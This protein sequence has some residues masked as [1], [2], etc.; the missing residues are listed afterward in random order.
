MGTL[1][2]ELASREILPGKTVLDLREYISE[3]HSSLSLASKASIFADAINRII[4]DKIPQLP[5]EQVKQFK[6]FLFRDVANKPTFS[7]NGSDIFISSL[8]LKKADDLYVE[9]LSQWLEETLRKPVSK[10]R[11]FQF[12]QYTHKTMDEFSGVDFGE[13]IESIEEKVGDI[14]AENFNNS[15]ASAMINPGS[16]EPDKEVEAFAD[17]AI[18]TTPIRY[19]S[20]DLSGMF[21]ANISIYKAKRK[22][23][24]LKKGNQAGALAAAGLVCITVLLLYFSATFVNAEKRASMIQPEEIVTLSL[25][26]L[27]ASKLE[28][29]ADTVQYENPA[30][31]MKATAYDLSFES[32][33]KERSHPEYGI[34]CTGTKASVG[35]T[36]AVDPAVIPLGSSVKITFPEKY[37]KLDG[38]YIA[39]DTGRLIKGNSIDVFFGEDEVGSS[40]V[41]KQAMEFGVQYV[42]VETIKSDEVNPN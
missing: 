8:K 31:R 33:G 2:T 23:T 15:S 41:N 25:E 39:E 6:T 34:T 19:E 24:F 20:R 1:L 10:E 37:S 9:G 21:Q 14:S 32:C 36:I 35:R 4:Q 30:I 28:I 13:L 11:L 29:A 18:D 17:P 22:M 5:D 38:I 12:I 27:P 16:F 7:I 40:A 26:K 42:M 3:K